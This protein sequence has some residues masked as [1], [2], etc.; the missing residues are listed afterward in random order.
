VEDARS[1]QERPDARERCARL[2]HFERLLSSN[3]SDEDADASGILYFKCHDDDICFWWQGRG[4]RLKDACGAA[5]I[6]NALQ[7]Q[8]YFYGP[9]HRM[10][11][12]DIE[13]ALK[14]RAE[15]SC[16]F[17]PRR[18]YELHKAYI[19]LANLAIRALIFNVRGEH[20][21]SFAR[22]PEDV[23]WYLLD[24]LMCR[25]QWLS[26]ESVDEQLERWL[27]DQDDQVV[28]TM[29]PWTLFAVGAVGSRRDG[30]SK[31]TLALGSE[32]LPPPVNMP[33]T[34]RSPQAR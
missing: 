15:A 27:E 3:K 26:S 23:G 21:V 30:P 25:P 1:A 33:R 19:L 11:S 14:K 29:R 34:H 4:R 13:E 28:V 12:S 18:M 7:E 31:V 2:E 5:A 20:W 6:N 32:F 10:S 17:V 22:D 16:Y 24:S 8:V 9:R